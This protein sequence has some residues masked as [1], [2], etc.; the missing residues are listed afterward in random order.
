MKIKYDYEILTVN[1]K[2]DLKVKLKEF[3]EKNNTTYSSVINDVIA[4]FLKEKK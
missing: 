2:K 4:E 3:V 1:L